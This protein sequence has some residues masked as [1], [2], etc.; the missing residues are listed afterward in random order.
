MNRV[1]FGREGDIRPAAV[2]G[3][4]V[5]L[6]AIAF[7][8]SML[9]ANAAPPAFGAP[10]EVSR[11]GFAKVALATVPAVLGNALGFYMSYRRHDK[12]ALVKFLAPAA[13]FYVAFMAIP[14]WGLL[15]GGTFTAFAVGATIN[16]VAV[17]VAVPAL[18]VLRPGPQTSRG[19]VPED[20]AELLARTAA[21]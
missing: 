11:F 2:V 8:V 6:S 15:A 9:V 10:G 20:A 21:K 4:G 18:L 13:G 14:A 16:T 5:L 3:V 7:A 19:P 1:M 12:R 17:G